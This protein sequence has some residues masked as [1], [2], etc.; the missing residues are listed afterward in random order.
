MRVKERYY[1]S[2]IEPVPAFA[3]APAAPAGAWP[4]L[5]GELV[6]ERLTMRPLGLDHLDHM[7]EL[8]ADPEVTRFLAPLDR[9]AHRARLEES[10]ES[11][12]ALGYG[13]AAVTETA[14]GRFVGRA[15]LV[16][17]SRMGEVELSWALHRDRWGL[18]Y[19]TEAAR[20]WARWG[21]RNLPVDYLTANIHPDNAASLAVA[22]KLGMLP[23]R[24]DTFHGAT[25]VVHAIGRSTPTA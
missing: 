12:R 16:W 25:V 8:Y 15:G 7:M 19:A 5:V 13:R 20:A 24:T 14:T 22:H 10:E 6:T 9:E 4:A 1:P 23:R 21:L 3:D 18:G 2:A 17:W 11:W